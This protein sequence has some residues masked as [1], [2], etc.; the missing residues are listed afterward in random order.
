MFF[1]E[2][3]CENLKNKPIYYTASQEYIQ[4]PENAGGGGDGR[5]NQKRIVSNLVIFK[6]S[7]VKWKAPGVQESIALELQ[8]N[9]LNPLCFHSQI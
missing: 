1:I 4:N 7:S 3:G 2:W 8:V 9:L 5:G 6:T